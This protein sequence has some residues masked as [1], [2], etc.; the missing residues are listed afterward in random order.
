MQLKKTNKTISTTQQKH[1]YRS[2]CSK[3]GT[4]CSKNSSVN[5]SVSIVDSAEHIKCEVLEIK[6]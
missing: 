4:K 6:G 2:K 3:C 5:I 1:K